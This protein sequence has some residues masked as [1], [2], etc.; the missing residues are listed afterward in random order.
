MHVLETDATRTLT[1]LH[2]VGRVI[3]R[4]PL[5]WQEVNTWGLAVRC[6]S[7]MIANIGPELG[8]FLVV[9]W[10]SR[11]FWIQATKTLSAN[12]G[13]DLSKI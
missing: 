9:N 11:L 4:W 3:A 5:L 13:R 1:L 8:T 10:L 2:A 7:P 12:I 6:S